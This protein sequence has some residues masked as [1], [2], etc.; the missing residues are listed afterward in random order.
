MLSTKLPIL[1]YIAV[2]I[3]SENIKIQSTKQQ[4]SNLNCKKIYLLTI[5]ITFHVV[6]RL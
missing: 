4:E 3:E 1:N 5:Y 2:M 6:K